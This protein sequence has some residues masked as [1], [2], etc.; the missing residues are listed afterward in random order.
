[1]WPSSAHQFNS[2]ITP[3]FRSFPFFTLRKRLRKTPFIPCQI[4]TFH[5]PKIHLPT[6]SRP[7]IYHV[8]KL[9]S[10]TQEKYHRNLQ[11][12]HFVEVTFLHHLVTLSSSHSHRPPI[13]RQIFTSIILFTI[14]QHTYPHSYP[15]FCGYFLQLQ[16]KIGFITGER[17]RYISQYRCYRKEKRRNIGR[18]I[19]YRSG[20]YRSITYRRLPCNVQEV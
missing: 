3:N 15:H 7:Q 17:D 10:H 2:H 11:S 12:H 13:H 8:I 18:G 6:L 5:A 14:Y 9:L 4:S 20:T 1:M 16:S 19:T